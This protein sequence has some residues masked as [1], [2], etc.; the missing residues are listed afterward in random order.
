MRK[1]SLH[2]GHPAG[3][4]EPI[5]TALLLAAGMG[6]RLAPFTDDVPKC[7]VPVS[8]VP[9]IERLVRILDDYGFERLVAVVGHRADSVRGFLGDSFGG[10]AVEYVVSPLFATTNSLYSLW[11]ARHL[12]DGPFLLVESDIVFDAP[13]LAPL[14]QPDRIAISAQL[15]WMSGT[16]VTLDARGGVSAFYSPP[17]GVYGRHCRAA[18][19]FIT[20]NLTSLARDTWAEARERL[21][22]HVAAGHG[23]YFHDVVF[24]EMTAAGTMALEAVR[25]PADRWYE[26]DTPADRDAAELVFPRR[27][28]AAGGSGRAA[29]SGRRP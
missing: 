18:D 19:H 10:V 15:P 20:V 21:D 3:G 27:L 11:L 8:G 17:P 1:L 2:P 28:Q 7:L 24:A 23:G 14:L 25:F 4:G 5:R 12:V 13:L 29:L 16:T 9:I 26:V 6:S 22:R